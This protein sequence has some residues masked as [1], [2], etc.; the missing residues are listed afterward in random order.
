MIEAL[1]SREVRKKRVEIGLK[2]NVFRFNVPMNQGYLLPVHKLDCAGYFPKL[3]FVERGSP[4]LGSQLTI[5]IAGIVALVCSA[6]KRSPP[7][8]NVDTA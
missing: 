2:K 1:H 5:W 4:C 3:Q 7:S 8:A 6:Y